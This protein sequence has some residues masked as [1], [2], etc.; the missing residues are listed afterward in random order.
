M[1][2]ILFCAI[3]TPRM[4]CSNT[5]QNRKKVHCLGIPKATDFKASTHLIYIFYY[6]HILTNCGNFTN[7]PSFYSQ[8]CLYDFLR[9]KQVLHPVTGKLNPALTF[10]LDSIAIGAC[11]FCSGKSQT[12]T[13]HWI[14]MQFCRNIQ[15]VKCLENSR[16]F[17]TGTVSSGAVCHRKVD[18]VSFVTL[19]SGTGICVSLHL[20]NP[21]PERFQKNPYVL[22]RQK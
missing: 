19:Y 1:K 16:E 13:A 12:M 18:G 17:S 15:S 11:C 21:L 3:I 2:Y 5:F 14:N 6:F 20:H 10:C 8:R 22:S 7:T 4:I 9:F